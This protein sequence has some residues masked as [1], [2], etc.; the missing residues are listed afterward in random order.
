MT[1]SALTVSI[2]LDYQRSNWGGWVDADRDCQ[3]TRTEIIEDFSVPPYKPECSATG[4]IFDPYTNLVTDVKRV[5]VDHVVALKDAF[6]SGGWKWS[7]GEKRAY[8]NNLAHL[9][10][11]DL[12]L[13]RSKGSGN[14]VEWLPP[15]NRCG[16]AVAYSVIKRDNDLTVNQFDQRIINACRITDGQLI[17][18]LR[19]TPV[20]VPSYLQVVVRD[21]LTVM[22]SV[23]GKDPVFVDAGV[24]RLIESHWGDVYDV[25]LTRTEEGYVYRLV[26]AAALQPLKISSSP[27]PPSV[28]IDFNETILVSEPLSIPR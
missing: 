24:R 7:R 22:E 8:T 14:L 13:N 1:L 9:L 16:Y 17:D 19:F 26:K 2:L 23:A 3:D 21:Y 18:Y 25:R 11:T 27:F 12:S 5:D 20:N 15:V 4:F 28:G 10:P 6:I